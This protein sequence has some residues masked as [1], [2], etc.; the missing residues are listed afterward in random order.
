M[1]R[2]HIVIIMTT[3]MRATVGIITKEDISLATK[4]ANVAA[5]RA[6]AVATM[7]NVIIITPKMSAGTGTAI[8]I[9][10]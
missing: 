2:M 4:T 5:V 1:I 8:R 7:A 6:S 9:D 3:T 10:V